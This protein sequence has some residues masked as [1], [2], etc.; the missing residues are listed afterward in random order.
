MNTRK[1]LNFIKKGGEIAIMFS[2]ENIFWYISQAQ[3]ID[4]LLPDDV[5]HLY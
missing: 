4:Q 1:N 3:Q 5:R 2:N